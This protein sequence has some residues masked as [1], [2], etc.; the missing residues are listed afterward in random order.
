M[1]YKAVIFDLDGV[2]VFTDKYHY[3]A[4]KKLAD[5]MGIEFTEKDNDRLRGVSR[6]ES[7]DIILEKYRGEPISP[8]KKKEYL[9][10]KNNTYRESLGEMNRGDVSDQVR[11]TLKRLKDAGYRLAIGSS[12]KNTAY[13]L[14]RCELTDCFEAVSDG[15][16]ITRSKPDPEVF[17]KAAELLSENPADCL[18]VEDADAGV[19]AAHAAGMDV[20]AIGAATASGRADH[21]LSKFEDLYDILEG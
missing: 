13:I 20:A 21:E 10:E 2:L 15:T 7:L 8:E 12:S 3:L 9:E 16:M 5:K 19:T 1:Q 11:Q 6:E 17:L 14:E 18:V 4:W